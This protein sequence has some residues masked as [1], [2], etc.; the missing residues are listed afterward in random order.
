M[1]ATR[2]CFLHA[3][4]CYLPDLLLCCTVFLTSDL[5]S[6]WSLSWPAA[7]SFLNY[8]NLHFIWSTSTQDPP[9]FSTQ[10]CWLIPHL[11]YIHGLMGAFDFY[12]HSGSRLL[13][14]S[15][16]CTAAWPLPFGIT[17]AVSSSLHPLLYFGFQ[18]YCISWI[19]TLSLIDSY[20][21][22]S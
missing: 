13:L 21:L 14:P 6:S 7:L 20:F 9:G 2:L 16:T 22:Y 19:L 12:L 5:I 17:P 10:L 3:P 1:F 4:G 11:L 18:F 8:Y 15:L